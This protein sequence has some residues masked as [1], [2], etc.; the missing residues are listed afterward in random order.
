MF[1]SHIEVENPVSTV[2]GNLFNF[3]GDKYVRIYC[4][5][6][7]GQLVIVYV[8]YRHT[9]LLIIVKCVAVLLHKLHVSLSITI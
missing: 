5:R 7:V 4:C 3:V 6:V 9:F 1:Q 8:S 2:N